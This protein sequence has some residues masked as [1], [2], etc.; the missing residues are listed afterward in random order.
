[1]EQKDGGGCALITNVPSTK[2]TIIVKDN[3]VVG[4]VQMFESSHEFDLHV[5]L[6][7]QT[8]LH[9]RAQNWGVDPK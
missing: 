1:M 9:T 4:M 5:S 2:E 7:M 3:H 8:Q 6:D